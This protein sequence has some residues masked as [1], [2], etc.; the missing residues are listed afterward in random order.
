M[1]E[2]KVKGVVQIGILVRNA[3]EAVRQYARLL[4]VNDWN[5]NLVDTDKG[6]GKNFRKG[7]TRIAVKAKI[8]WATIGGIEF[9][10]IEP[11]DTTSIYAMHLETHGPG[12][13]HVM[14]DT[15]DYEHTV[16]FL[17]DCGAESIVS[18]ELQ[19]TRFQLFDTRNTLGL[20][21][22]FAVGNA[23]VPDELRKDQDQA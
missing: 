16:S 19:E 18:G 14:F 6:K 17:N 22:E 11:Q 7:R 8:A 5:I 1:N 15:D 3:D 13:H 9:E 2:A 12:I 4:G 21:S 10:L 20:I 23:L